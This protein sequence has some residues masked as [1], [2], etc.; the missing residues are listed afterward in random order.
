MCPTS[1]ATPRLTSKRSRFLLAV[2]A[3]GAFAF[4][5]Y[6]AVTGGF[7]TYVLGIRVSSHR[8]V[9]AMSIG[10]IAWLMLGSDAVRTR[11][12]R[13]G[14]LLQRN[15]RIAGIGIA[16]VTL[17]VGTSCGAFTAAGADPYGYVSQA[18]L[19]TTGSVVQ[20]QNPLAREAPWANAAWSFSPLGYLPTD[21]SSY[22]VPAYPAGLP[23]QM[24]LA[25][26]VGGLAG[27]LWRGADTWRTRGVAH[28]RPRSTRL[29]I[30]TRTGRRGALCAAAPFSCFNSFSP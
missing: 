27:R 4:S 12:V 19:W 16:A 11:L 20:P 25:M 28:V 6:I 3:A 21:D 29:G 18:R 2:L 1:V 9:P 24:A 30:G 10:W 13:V 17:I 22:V 15:S 5:L 7:T 14:E 23:L 26:K 8:I